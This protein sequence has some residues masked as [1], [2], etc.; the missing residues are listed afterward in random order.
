MTNLTASFA[1]LG[2]IWCAALSL[3]VFSRI[4]SRPRPRLENMQTGHASGFNDSTT[5]VCTEN[6]IRVDEVAESPKLAQ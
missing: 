6:L 1:N 2:I 4:G 5:V 3:L